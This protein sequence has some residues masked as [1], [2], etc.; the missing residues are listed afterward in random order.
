[1]RIAV[2]GQGSTAS[3]YATTKRQ[4]NS[5]VEVGQTYGFGSPLHIA[6]QAL[7]PANGDGVG[8]I[9]V[10]V[11]PLE[12]DNGGVA[13]TGTITVS[14][15][16]TAVGS[17]TVSINGIQSAGFVVNVDDTADTVATAVNT[18]IAAV[19]GLPMTSVVTS[20][21]VTLTSKW[22]GL[23]ANDLRI[24]VQGPTNT[25]IT[26]AVVNP[27]DG[28]GNPDVNVALNQIGN[29]WEV[30]VLNC[31]NISD[32]STLN[33]Y[34]TFGESR[35]LPLVRRPMLVFTGNTTPAV[36]DAITVTDARS[37]DRSNVQLVSPGSA[38]LPW[39]VAGRELTRIAASANNNPPRDYGSQ[40]VAGLMPGTDMQ[41]W[42]YAERDRAVKA[43]SSTVEV[44]D[45]VVTLSDTVTMYHPEGD[46]TPAYRYVVDIIKVMNV[47]FNIDLIFNTVEW[48]GAPLIPD[49]Q[50]TTNREARKPK[51]AVAALNVTIDN[52]GLEAIISDPA[53]AKA[54]TVAVISSSN[55][56]RLDI[57]TTVQVSGNDNITSIDLRWGFF[58]GTAPLV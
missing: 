57:A 1:M 38:E 14:G 8:T 22:K 45:G 13:G 4:V 19:V 16:A 42:E 7:L 6:V 52:L 3:T 50:P 41:Q 48:D 32:T 56:K 34:M 27:T 26:F 21:I 12:D 5:A 28:A 46:P 40:T 15:T 55:P 39:F 18:A 49:D 23:S 10:T 36:A 17:Y 58:F 54:A 44:R 24:T 29:V 11:Y 31:L 33:K 37:L 51:D 2:V 47:I 9:P 35:W 43:G 53:T 30:I 20:S 25:G